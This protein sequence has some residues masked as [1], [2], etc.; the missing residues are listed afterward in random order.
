MTEKELRNLIKNARDNASCL[1]RKIKAGKRVTASPEYWDNVAMV[2]RADLNK[3][4]D[5]LTHK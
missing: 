5:N 3:M 1:R 2:Y 4:L